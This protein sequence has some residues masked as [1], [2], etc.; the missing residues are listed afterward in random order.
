MVGLLQSNPIVVVG[1]AAM[2][3]LRNNG[4]ASGKHW[5]GI[6]ENEANIVTI[7]KSNNG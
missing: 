7:E 1:E 2:N 4:V 6:N 3:N 5:V